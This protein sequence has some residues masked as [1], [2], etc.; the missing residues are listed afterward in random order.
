[1]KKLLL[2]WACLL[3]LA[4]PLQAAAAP[5]DIIIMRIYESRKTTIIITRGEGKSEKIEVENGFTDKKL[6]EANEGY[7]KVFERLYQE[8]YTVQSTFSTV[9][10]ATSSF[11]TVL[12]V[13]A[14]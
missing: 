1:M 8:G 2:L 10:D 3:A 7:Y 11:T 5:P 4:S 13:K 14:R 9:Y 6:I 12:F